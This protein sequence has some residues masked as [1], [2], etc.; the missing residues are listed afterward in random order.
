MN[1]KD[2]ETAAP[3]VAEMLQPLRDALLAPGSAYET[4]VDDVR[5]EAMAVFRHR[6]RS[7][8]ELLEASSR[9]GERTYL[10]EGEVR[11][12]FARH[13]AMVDALAAALQRAHGVRPGDRVAIL[14]ANRWEWIVTF[15]A[16]TSAGAVPCAFNGYWTP[17]E[18]VHALELAEPTV[19]V[20]DATRLARLD[21]T[22][23]AVPVI[24]MEDDLPAL[25]DQHAGEHPTPVATDEDDPA[26]LIFTSGTTGRP[27]AVT[28]SH[29]AIVGFVQLNTFNEA[30]G[31]VAMGGP[32]PGV[33]DPV[34]TSDEVV[35][36]TS[37]L[38][39]TS[40][41]Y[42]AVVTAM[43]K[44]CEVVLLPGRFDPERVLEVIDRE[45]VT[46]WMALGSAAPRV[47][48]S[49]ALG[50]YDT[51]SVR[52]LGVGGATVSPAVQQRLRQAFPSTSG[53]LGMGYTST[54]AAAVVANIGGPDFQVRPT[55]TGR[56]TPTTEIELRD[57]A[58]RPVAEGELGEV[59]VRSPYLMLGYWRDP[60]ATAAALKPGG[61]LAMGDMARMV[62]GWL[63]IDARARDMILVSA[64]NVSPSE[65]EYRLDEHPGVV[66]AAVLAVDDPLTG[67]AVCA[68]VVVEP[69]GATTAD[70][71]EA[72]CRESLAHYKVPT[73]W[74]LVHDPLPRTP[75][76][77][78]V[79]HRIRDEL[80]TAAATS[81]DERGR[82]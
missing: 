57:D 64:E 6:F 45:K 69:T 4:V 48:S 46:L 23:V 35:L 72:W 42:G 81:D 9:F 17:D 58:G 25:V 26:A 7:L 19:L 77:K 40:M 74:H 28:A 50:R 13:L 49:P 63:H 61:W 54:E 55:S 68:V 11:I 65:V 10:V 44:G 79:K 78:L 53:M 66:E 16:A 56:A 70:E 2:Q 18:V 33:G 41:L 24:T 29:R 21:G 75:S 62:D 30:V 60:E 32:M 59:H 76:G 73:R 37:P 38:F 80:V 31:A 47:S 20:A 1:E 52:M 27:K 15:W 82:S 8:R 22:P 43:V 39:H 71:L 34:P 67:D 36:A 14:A 3:S 51:S 5:G 12:D